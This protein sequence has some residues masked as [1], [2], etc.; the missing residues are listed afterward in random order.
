MQSHYSRFVAVAVILSPEWRW[1]RQQAA[2]RLKP[3]NFHLATKFTLAL[4]CRVKASF[5]DLEEVVTVRADFVDALQSMSL[6]K[7]PCNRLLW[8]L[9]KNMLKIVTGH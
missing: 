4:H 3:L 2:P 7:V 6:P 9:G 5:V 8:Y 1:R